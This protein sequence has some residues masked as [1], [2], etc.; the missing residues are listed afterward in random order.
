MNALRVEHIGAATLYLGDCLEILPT[1]GKVDH[2]ITDP[3]YEDRLHDGY[4]DGRVS[5]PGSTAR[6]R[7]PLTFEGI[8][9]TRDQAAATIVAACSGWAL[10]FCLPIGVY[11]WIISLEAAGAKEDTTFPWIKPDATPRFNGQ[12]PARAHEEIVTV[13]CS[14]R[15]RRWNGGGRRV[16]FTYPTTKREGEHPNEKPLALMKKLVDLFTQPGELVCDPY[17]GSGTTGVACLSHGRRFIGIERDPRYFDMACRRIEDEARQS[18]LFGEPGMSVCAAEA[19]GKPF[20]PA[21]ADA[22]F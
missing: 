20:R 2:I 17:M 18:R 8:D 4:A 13:W 10:V 21:R 15:K 5:G 22:R 12:G 11:P 7:R 9:A 16:V 1:L 19:C 3:P 6:H 14:R